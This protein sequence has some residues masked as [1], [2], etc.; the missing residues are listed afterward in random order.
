MKKSYVFEAVIMLALILSIG[1]LYLVIT[2][3]PPQAKGWE[4]QVNGSVDRMFA[5]SDDTLY[6]IQGNNINAV[7]SDGSAAWH[8]EV[9]GNWRVLDVVSDS[10]YV[11]ICACERLSTEAIEAAASGETLTFFNVR[12]KVIAISP[13]GEIGW[14]YPFTDNVSSWDLAG[15]TRPDDSYLAR[16]IVVQAS[17]GHIYVFHGY[18]EDVLSLDGRRLFSIDGISNLATVDNTGNVYAIRAVRPGVH[19]NGSWRCPDWTGGLRTLP[20]D[21]RF[22][23]EDIHRVAYDPTYMIKTS[24]IDMYRPDGSLLWSKDIGEKI[25][26]AYNDY[27]VGEPHFGSMTYYVN[28]MLYVPVRNGVA[29]LDANGTIKWV[30]HLGEDRRYVPFDILPVDRY[31]NVFMKTVNETN[32]I[33]SVYMITPEGEVRP[34]VWSY[35]VFTRLSPDA[36]GNDTI[37]SLKYDPEMSSFESF[38]NVS[39]DGKFGLDTLTACDLETGKVL[40]SF[41]IPSEDMHVI[42]LNESNVGQALPAMDPGVVININEQAKKYREWYG[43]PIEQDLNTNHVITMC[44]GNDMVYMSYYS[45]V[46][47]YPVL[48]N[49]SRSA[50]VNC[51]YAIGSNGTLIWKKPLDGLVLKTVAGN[52]TVYYSTEGGKIGGNASGAAAGIALAAVSYLFIR[53]FAIGAVA[54]ARSRLMT[55]SN[56]NAILKCIGE[57]PGATAPDL[58]RGL[59]MNS[60]TIRYHLLILMLNHKIVIH[61]ENDKYLRYFTNGSTYS[62]AERSM[63]SL[64]RRKPLGKALGLLVENPGMSNMEISRA[65]NISSASTIQYMNELLDRGIVEKVPKDEKSYAYYITKEHDELIRKMIKWV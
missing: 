32:G 40:W 35:P 28:D 27:E 48:F 55:N 17:H 46:Y 62:E 33:T 8:I 49:S 61:R 42:V 6:L 19:V 15:L 41:G 58:A 7:S 13:Q 38:D 31:G 43:E 22:G 65:M 53:F 29:A 44:S 37:Y 1:I 4:I 39:R 10:E 36:D 2:S 9:P 54:R 51:L 26:I 24:I 23:G 20:D 14:E 63:L 50:Y 12:A 3:P 45:I 57:N 56:R 47:E 30:L 25:M 5:G 16:D 18:R 34:D 52:G 11:Y 64:V 21:P 60:G 59:K